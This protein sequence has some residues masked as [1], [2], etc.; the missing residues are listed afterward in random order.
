LNAAIVAFDDD[1]SSKANNAYAEAFATL[2]VKNGE[3]ANLE[4]EL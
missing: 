3:L 4:A 1:V 2:S